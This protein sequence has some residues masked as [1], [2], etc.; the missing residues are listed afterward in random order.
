[1]GPEE[2]VTSATRCPGPGGPAFTAYAW[3]GLPG[4]Q[5]PRLYSPRR[6]NQALPAPPR[7]AHPPGAGSFLGIVTLYFP[8]SWGV[9][10]RN[11]GR[12]RSG[13]VSRIGVCTLILGIAPGSDKASSTNLLVVST[14]GQRV[15]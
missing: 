10:V 5:L 13:R 14:A 7:P 9:T 15:A 8:L 4:H 2:R 11:S 3:G 1:M 12:S 6:G